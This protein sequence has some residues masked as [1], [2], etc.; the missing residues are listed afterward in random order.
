MSFVSHF[1]AYVN[2]IS[3]DYARIL[4][5]LFIAALSVSLWSIIF[6]RRKVQGVSTIG[7]LPG[8]PSPS[9]WKGNLKQLTDLKNGWDFHRALAEYGPAVKLNGFFRN[10]LFYTFDPQAMHHI[11]VKD[12][13]SFYRLRLRSS[14]LLFGKGLLSTGGE[15][16]RKQRKMLNPVFS[17]AHMRS[18]MPTFYDVVDQLETALS[19]RVQNGP[20]EIDLLGWMARTA[21]ELIG[22]SGF[23]Y[24]FDNMVEDAPKHKYSI[25]V[26][27]LVPALSR[28]RV[29]R[30]F[31]LP[32]ALKFIPT[33][34]F[35]LS[36]EHVPMESSSRSPR[37]GHLHAPTFR[38]EAVARQIGRGKDIL[39]VLMKENLQADN[40]DKLDE[41][42]IIGQMTTFIF[43]AMDTTSNGMSRI[44]HLLSSHQDVQDK[45]RQEIIEVRKNR[46]GERLSYDELVALPYLDAVCRETLRLY[47]PVSSIDRRS[48]E[49]R[50]VPL[51][52]PV[53]GKDGISEVTEVFIPK[54]TTV[55]ISILNANRSTDLWGPDALEW[56]P[57][58]WLTPL[59]ESI[60]ESKVP[61]VYAHL[62]TFSGGGRSCIGFKFS[63]LEMKVVISMLVENFKFSLPPKKDIFWQMSG[64]S[65]P[66]V[67]GGD[68]HARLP[69]MVE[70]AK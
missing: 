43:A 6:R 61:G 68:G 62:M 31:I 55:V 33:R 70:L 38:D 16:H 10:K 3:S 45:M 2:A 40:E 9:W 12:A 36:Y 47:P 4:Q 53:R 29:E 46:P 1:Q 67:V 52:R 28:L 34:V 18:M 39:S 19:N 24:S 5:S 21:L 26:K 25:V 54:S 15:H 58:R 65:S 50:V 59:P 13:A 56:K 30:D 35:N 41:D 57:E 69:L 64:I 22:Q 23:G 7:E 37:Y 60:M 8:P 44:L 51:S 20:T 48:S 17:I 63:Q 27:D 66:V 11:L 42:E 14:T 32:F 49:D